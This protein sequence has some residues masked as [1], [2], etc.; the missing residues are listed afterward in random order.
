MSKFSHT[1][2]PQGQRVCVAV[3]RAIGTILIIASAI[4]GLIVGMQDI[5]DSLDTVKYN[6]AG[7]FAVFAGGAF[8]GATVIGL[9]C[10]LQILDEIRITLISRLTLQKSDI[11]KHTE[12]FTSAREEKSEQDMQELLKALEENHK[13][14]NQK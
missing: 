4:A 14:L 3:F 5:S 11:E 6:V 10:I 12:K 2:G 13:K 8:V 1:D 9:S 7:G